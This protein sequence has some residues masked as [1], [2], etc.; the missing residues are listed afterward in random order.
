MFTGVI[1]EKFMSKYIYKYEYFE[2]ENRIFGQTICPKRL[3]SPEL[4]G[5][6]GLNFDRF[7][8]G[9]YMFY[10]YLKFGQ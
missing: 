6:R 8:L 3:I 2:D 7:I 1:P 5:F 10:W 4:E 9:S